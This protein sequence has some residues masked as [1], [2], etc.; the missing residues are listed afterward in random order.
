MARTTGYTATAAL[1]LLKEGLFDRKGIIVPEYIGQNEAC[2]QFILDTLKKKN[3]VY[4]ET[5][6]HP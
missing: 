3:I 1:R 2:V 4:K 5:I 6:T